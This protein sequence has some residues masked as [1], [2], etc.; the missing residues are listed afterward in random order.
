MTI[1]HE[2]FPLA[3]MV[4]RDSTPSKEGARGPKLL[5]KGHM[6]A[7]RYQVESFIGRGGMG[8]VYRVRDT[9]EDRVLALKILN[10]S[11]AEEEEGEQR[12]MREIEVLPKI[13]HPAVPKIYGWGRH[14]DQL[15][16]VCEFISGRDLKSDIKTRGPWPS[17]E[18]AKLCAEIAD[19]LSVAH[20]MGIIHRDI[21]PHNIMISND[22]S[23]RLLD[24]GVARKTGAGME[25]LTKTGMIVGTPEYMS[26]EQFG[27]HRVDH[28]SDIYSLGVVLFE[29]VT[30]QVPYGGETPVAIAVKVIQQP[31]VAPR[32]VRKDVPDW[33][34]RIVLK[35]LEKDPK[36]R[37]VN[38][39]QLAEELRKPK[40]KAKPQMQ[41]LPNGDSVV[42][43]DTEDAKV[44][45]MLSSPKEKPLWTKSMALRLMDKFYK[46]DEILPPDAR[47]PRWRYNF[48]H[49]PKDEILR[50]LIDYDQH[51]AASEK[52]GFLGKI[53][54][55][56]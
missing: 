42:I 4:D 50:G 34:D 24:F 9:A 20:S 52:K 44:A 31:S 13:K 36:N 33:V 25:T 3:Q 45:L 11:I 6:F 49:W 23:V 18:A 19:A 41:W 38:A 16:F 28:R 54:G 35:C 1:A 14:E 8:S 43:D 27:T 37:Y 15:Y 7:E 12:F 51:S 17:E 10:R 26:P 46:L 29:L 2:G 56:N 39:I 40:A 5:P 48:S 21:K 53:F 22:G 30:G 32:S 47:T 55:K